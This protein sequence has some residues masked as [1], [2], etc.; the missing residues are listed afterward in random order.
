LLLLLLL[1]LLRRLRIFADPMQEAL[2]KNGARS[3]RDVTTY[4]AHVITL[5]TMSLYQRRWPVPDDSTIHRY[6]DVV[7]YRLMLL[8][9]RRIL[10]TGFIEKNSFLTRQTLSR[11]CVRLMLWVWVVHLSVTIY[12][13]IPWYTCIVAKRLKGSNWVFGMRVSTLDSFSRSINGNRGG[14]ILWKTHSDIHWLPTV[15][16]VQPLGL[17]LLL[18]LSERYRFHRCLSVCLFV[19]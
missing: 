9:C 10:R 3:F 13:F 4:F 16:R 5:A 1:L 6:H 19:C 15:S 8:L 12:L 11:P 17:L 14:G 2:L 18:P 7:S